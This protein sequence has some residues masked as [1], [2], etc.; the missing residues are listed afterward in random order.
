MHGKKLYNLA[1]TVRY[2]KKTFLLVSGVQ[3]VIRIG[4]QLVEADLNMCT[5][6]AGYQLSYPEEE[7]LTLSPEEC[8]SCEKK[9]LYVCLILNPQAGQMP[10]TH[11]MSDASFIRDKVPM[12]KEEVRE[13][14]ICKL[15]LHEGAVVYD[16]GSGTGSIAMEMAAVDP[17]VYVYAI[18]RKPEAVTL[19][20]RNRQQL[21]LQNIEIVEAEA[22]DGMEELPAPTHAFI[23]GSGGNLKEILSLLYRKNPTMR[24]VINAISMETICE[25]REVLEQFPIGHEEIVQMQVSRSAKVG[26]YHLMKAE[27]PVWICAFDFKRGM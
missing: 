13:V 20:E 24:V 26:S 21:G 2:E 27:N 3:D 14:S 7:I 4:Q 15:H 22:P 18:E 16:V 11:G 8:L 6:I 9:G 12:T 23:G 1:R 10:V 17:S 25:M 5:V 19:I